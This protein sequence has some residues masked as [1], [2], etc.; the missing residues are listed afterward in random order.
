MVLVA[1]QMFLVGSLGIPCMASVLWVFTHFGTFLNELS[2]PQFLAF[3]NV[4]NR[5]KKSQ[6]MMCKTC[7]A[8]YISPVLT[9]LK[10]VFLK[11]YKRAQQNC[12]L[13]CKCFQVNW[14]LFSWALSSKESLFSQIHTWIWRN[15]I[16]FL[17]R[18]EPSGRWG[19]NGAL[20]NFFLR[21]RWRE[22]RELDHFRAPCSLL[23]KSLPLS[24]GCFKL[25]PVLL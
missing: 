1:V 14:P 5:V 18:G 16:R 22:G 8:A 9:K 24:G 15:G 4:M 11:Y 21:W 19:G 23:F 12:Y 7:L 2:V 13:A 10:Q 6:M 17:G 25:Y 3:S 20:V